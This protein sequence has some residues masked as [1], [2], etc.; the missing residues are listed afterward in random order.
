MRRTSQTLAVAAAL[1][2]HPNGR[3]WGYPL[4]KTSG[5]RSGVLYPILA[6]MLNEGWLSD[7]WESVDTAVTDRRPPR[8]YYKLT[9][10]GVVA[11][12]GML[13]AA[14]DHLSATTYG[15]GGTR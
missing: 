7:D 6:R 5:V 15:M 3:H 10:A 13:D 9:V 1:M 14:G 11:L 4:T 8:R 12:G 2:D